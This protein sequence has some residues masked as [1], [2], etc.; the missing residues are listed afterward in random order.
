MNYFTTDSSEATI[1]KTLGFAYCGATKIQKDTRTAVQFNFEMGD[2][3]QIKEI[4]KEYFN[5]TL[6]LDAYDL[7]EAVK[8]IRKEIYDNK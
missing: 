1:L 3:E 4:N 8:F 2:V 7:L 5:H 6:S